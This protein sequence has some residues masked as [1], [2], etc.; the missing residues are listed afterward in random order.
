[1]AVEEEGRNWFEGQP[2]DQV[3]VRPEKQKPI[4]LQRS[5]GFVNVFI[6][7]TV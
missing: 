3:L 5:R 2:L 6:G 4:L 1:M 7:F